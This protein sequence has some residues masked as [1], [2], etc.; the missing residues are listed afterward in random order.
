MLLLCAFLVGL[1]AGLR[2][3]LAPAIVSWS[4]RLGWLNIEPTYMALMEYRITVAIFTLL[5]VCELVVDK[6]PTT[7]SRKQPV[8]FAIR[9]LSGGL[10]GA[11]VGAAGGKLILGLI[12]GIIGA[13][14]GTLGGAAARAKMAAAFHR[15]FPAAILEDIAAIAIGFFSVMRLR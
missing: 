1:V 15:D 7:P 12:F 8:P 5:A 9:I 14:A 2:S 10:V 4:A 3:M 6:L 13:V 11:T